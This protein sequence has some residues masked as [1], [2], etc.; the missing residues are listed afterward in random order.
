MMP[1][2]PVWL[3][4]GGEK[5]ERVQLLFADLAPVYD[6]VNRVISLS[7]DRR[8]RIATVRALEL[9]AGDT[10]ADI[11]CGTGAFMLP[12]REAVGAS[13]LV[14][15]LDFCAP[16]LEHARA[17]AV[18]GE[19]A[20]SDACA[21]P[22]VSARFDAVTIGWG[23]RNVSDLRLALAETFRI[24][25]P[26]GRLASIDMAQPRIAPVN[27]VSRRLF[28]PILKAAGARAGK[29]EAYTYLAES[30]HRFV[31]RESLADA[32]V[33]VGFAEVRYRDF[34]LGHVCLHVARKP[35]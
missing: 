18:P 10:V 29:A 31:S 2:K 32:M 9:Q 14:L 4:D 24:L 21:L 34:A 7:G 19:L 25:K 17:K 23:L 1:A 22:L 11:C 8:W 15:G 16:M 20:A 35:L 5:R 6:R 26:G 13:G 27:A 30:T 28:R 3:A 33:A 12:L